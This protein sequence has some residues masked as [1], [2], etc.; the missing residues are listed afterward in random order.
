MSRKY[1]G[2]DTKNALSDALLR[3]LEEGR[4]LSK[5]PIRELTESCD[6]DRQTFYYHFKNIYELAEY[7]YKH[8]VSSIF[9]AEGMDEVYKLDWRY[10]TERIL[11]EIEKNQALRDVIIP[12]LGEAPIRKGVMDMVE[13]TFHRNFLP[14]LLE[15]G[16]PEQEALV[17][18]K[19]LSY[20]L[21]AV[22]IAW[23]NKETDWSVSTILDEVERMRADYLRG[24]MARPRQG[25]AR[26]HMS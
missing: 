25:S 16:L 1:T 11:H 23:I 17:S 2:R 26:P 12:A 3:K 6:L 4:Q 9:G 15:A 21:Q 19:L 22:L 5:I 24:I 14:V 20:S 8:V 7:T 10:R 18:T 13:E